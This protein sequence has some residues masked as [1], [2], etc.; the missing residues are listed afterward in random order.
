MPVKAVETPIV[1]DIEE[2][3]HAAG[4]A[5]AKAGDMNKGN[6]LVAPEIAKG[7]RKIIFEHIQ[8]FLSKLSFYWLKF[9]QK[10]R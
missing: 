10:D 1:E 2:D 5:D 4:K 6:G 9:A 3:E 8:R 7:D